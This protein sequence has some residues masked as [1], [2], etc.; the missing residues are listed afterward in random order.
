MEILQSIIAFIPK[1]LSGMILLLVYIVLAAS[2]VAGIF[3]KL[4]GNQF[5]GAF[6]SFIF[7]PYGIVSAWIAIYKESSLNRKLNR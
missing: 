5:F 2:W 7:P 3:F 6:L 4:L 1:Y